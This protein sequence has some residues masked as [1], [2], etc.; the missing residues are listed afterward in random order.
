IWQILNNIELKNAEGKRY[1]DDD[2]KQILFDEVNLKGKIT[3]AKSL[4]ILG[5]KSKGVKINYEN[6]EGNKTNQVLYDAYLKILYLEGYD[7]LDLLKV[8]SNKDEVTLSDLDVSADSIKE[9]V[10]SI[11]ETLGIDVSILEFNAELDGKAF[12]QQK[13]YQLWHLLYS[14]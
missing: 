11:F 8:K 5:Q 6:I 13:S 1:L 12:E 10:R 3:G 7:V 2:E 9:M 4:Q 14:Y